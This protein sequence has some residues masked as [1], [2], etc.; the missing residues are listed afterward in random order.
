M[1]LEHGPFITEVMSRSVQ[2]AP[3]ETG[4]E[5]AAEIMRSLS[6][7]HLPIV[8]DGAVIGLVSDQDIQAVRAQY[9]QL[10]PRTKVSV[11]DI[12]RRDFYLAAPD[13]TLEEVANELV[14]RHASA[15]VIASGEKTLGIFTLSDAC[16][17]MVRFFEE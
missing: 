12:A 13:T 1:E 11:G 15:V 4:I 3:A 17:W 16:R 14:R 6:V 5:E 10:G 9:G 2:T 7:H 8:K